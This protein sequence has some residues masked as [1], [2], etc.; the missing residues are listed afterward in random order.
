MEFFD[1]LNIKFN[2]NCRV[3]KGKG[4]QIYKYTGRAPFLSNKIREFFVFIS[5]MLKFSLTPISRD[6]RI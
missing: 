1:K 2:A 6:F 3:Q 4:R 5:F